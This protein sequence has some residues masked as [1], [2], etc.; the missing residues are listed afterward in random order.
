MFKITLF[1]GRVKM[2]TL[3]LSKASVERKTV[4]S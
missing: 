1:E 2:L 4:N 3:N